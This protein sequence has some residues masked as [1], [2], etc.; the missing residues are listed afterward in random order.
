VWRL[1][2]I[3]LQAWVAQYHYTHIVWRLSFLIHFCFYFWVLWTTIIFLCI[4]VVQEVLKSNHS[5]RKC[6][7]ATQQIY[8]TISFLSQLLMPIKLFAFCFPYQLK[9]AQTWSAGYLEVGHIAS[10][11]TP[12]TREIKVTKFH[13]QP[14]ENHTSKDLFRHSHVLVCMSITTTLMYSW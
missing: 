2:Q 13:S 14:P 5:A 1:I 6:P 9:G 12:L 7:L 11:I 4:H 8:A 3:F 10:M